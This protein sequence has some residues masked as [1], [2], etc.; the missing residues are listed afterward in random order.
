MVARGAKNVKP[1]ARAEKYF[2]TGLL[3]NWYNKLSL[4]TQMGTTQKSC[5]IPLIFDIIINVGFNRY[6]I[7]P[8][9]FLRS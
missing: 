1:F 7:K 9:I 8:L 6:W 5:V 3:K 2:L 4:T